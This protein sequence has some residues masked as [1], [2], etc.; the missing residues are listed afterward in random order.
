MPKSPLGRCPLSVAELER[1][2]VVDATESEVLV[3]A[4]GISKHFPIKRGLFDRHPRQVKAVDGVDF[5][6][7]RG[8]TL[9]LVGESGCGK[10]TTGRLILR[11]ETPTAGELRYNGT[12][13][14]HLQ[15]SKLKWYRS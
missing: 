7:R 13:V 4:R 10:T 5:T 15:G 11:L 2:P 1:I 9:G 8:K 3:E 6:L 14:A 12:D